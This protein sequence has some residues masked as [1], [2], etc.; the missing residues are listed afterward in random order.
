MISKSTLYWKTKTKLLS[1]YILGQYHI[2]IL[3]LFYFYIAK[4]D[5]IL[6]IFL[7]RT[8]FLNTWFDIFLYTEKWPS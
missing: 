6:N 3:I 8:F 1:A 5:D 4:N 7:F 2:L